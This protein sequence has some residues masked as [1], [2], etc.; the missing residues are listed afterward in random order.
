MSMRRFFIISFL[1]VLSLKGSAQ[2]ENGWQVRI[3]PQVVFGANND[4]QRPNDESGTR[5]SL[6]DD[7]NRKNGANFSPRIE[8]EY[9]IRRHHIIATAAW[10]TDKF[11]GDAPRDIVYDGV[12][13]VPGDRV[14]AV[15]RFN[16]YR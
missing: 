6:S 11:D 15:Y 12:R 9:H 7:F 2:S 10:L 5:F 4:V 14:K 3:L 16:T 1:A 13:F 8:V